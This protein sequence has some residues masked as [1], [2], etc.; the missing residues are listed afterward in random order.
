MAHMTIRMNTFNEVNI[1]VCACVLVSHVE[2]KLTKLCHSG[3][4]QLINRSGM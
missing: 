1:C 3:G 2:D 4:A